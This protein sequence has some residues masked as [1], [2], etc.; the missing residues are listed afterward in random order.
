[1]LETYFVA[2]ENMKL[3]QL[4]G[5]RDCILDQPH[6][7]SKTLHPKKI[8]EQ[9]YMVFH[10]DLQRHAKQATPNYMFI[11]YLYFVTKVNT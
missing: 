7:W 1:M 11:F 9:T 5:A 4:I 6:A 8:D 10:E 3:P 2:Y